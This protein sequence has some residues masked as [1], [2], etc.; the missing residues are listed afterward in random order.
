MYSKAKNRKKAKF[1]K[2]AIIDNSTKFEGSNFIGKKTVVLNSY[3]GFGTYISYESS[4]NKCKIGRYTCIGPKVEIVA[5]KHPTNFASM[6]PF[7]YTKSN[8]IGKT[9]VGKNKFAEH[10]YVDSDN[11]Y[12]VEIGNDV[13]IGYGAKI[14][15]GIHIGDGAVVAAN[16]MVVKDVPPYAIVGG[17]PAKVLRY[18]FDDERIKKL[19]R[20]QWWKQEESTIR[21]YADLFSDVDAMIN[22]FT[23]N[24]EKK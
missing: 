6:H 3:M 13:W 12:Y 11:K 15:D 21:L 1:A 8:Q 5:G 14:M 19:L 17:V 2:T 20:I 7:F 22:T 4:I 10:E 23:Q 16:A 9:F 18:R 24:G